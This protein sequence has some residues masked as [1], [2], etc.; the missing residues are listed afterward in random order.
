MDQIQESLKDL[1]LSG[2]QVT[3]YCTLLSIGKGSAQE[4]AH[5]AGLK[6][7]TTY[8]VLEELIGTGL[9]LLIPNSK[10]K[11]YRALSPHLLLEKRKTRL[12]NLEK[13]VP[14]VEAMLRDK[15]MYEKPHVM[16]FEGIEGIKKIVEYNLEELQGGELKEFLLTVDEETLKKFGKFFNRY[17]KKLQKLGIKERGISPDTQE[18]KDYNEKYREGNNAIK[19]VSK[20]TW[21]SNVAIEIGNTFVKF[22]DLKNLQGIVIQNSAIAEAMSQIF[23]MSWKG[24]SE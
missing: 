17:D 4:I 10:K 5:E 2:K 19:I 6:R 24:V 9:A 3:I 22:Y 16:F 20:E 13:I 11:L 18:V 15:G 12:R 21:N 14:E 1:G 23:E 8:A 7:S